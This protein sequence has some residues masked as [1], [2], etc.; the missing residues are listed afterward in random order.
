MWYDEN[1]S[2]WHISS[3]TNLKNYEGEIES[4]LQWIKPYIESGS[5]AKEMYAIV[6]YE[7][8]EE[9]TIYYL[10]NR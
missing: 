4:F 10:E 6:T 3:R 2:Q 7:E 1:G 8:S 9:P 5:G